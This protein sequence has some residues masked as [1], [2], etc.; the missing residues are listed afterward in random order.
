MRCRDAATQELQI[1]AATQELQIGA[2]TQELLSLIF[3]ATVVEMTAVVEMM[4]M[5]PGSWRRWMSWCWPSALRR[6]SGEDD[7][8]PGAGIWLCDEDEEPTNGKMDLQ[9]GGGAS[10]LAY[11]GG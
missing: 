1:G 8:L 5:F 7:G 10:A 4:D 2:A 3:P 11:S 9:T 6:R